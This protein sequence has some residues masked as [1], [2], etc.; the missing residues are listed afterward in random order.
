MKQGDSPVSHER[1]MGVSRE[2]LMKLSRKSLCYETV[3]NV[4][5]SRQ[6]ESALTSHSHTPCLCSAT[7]IFLL[8]FAT[9]PPGYT[10]QEDKHNIVEA[11]AAGKIMSGQTVKYT[12]NMMVVA[13]GFEAK[14]TALRD[15]V[16]IYI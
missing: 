16:C 13:K 4:A 8:A 10:M 7:Y 12:E 3:N 5:V 2:T 1:L 11:G 6:R 14:M 15:R 9:L